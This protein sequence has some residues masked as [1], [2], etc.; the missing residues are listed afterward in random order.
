MSKSIGRRRPTPALH[1]W[2]RPLIGGVAILG[3]LLTGYLALSHFTKSSVA[4][5]TSGCDVVLTSKYAYFLGM[6]L[7]LFGCLAYCAMAVFALAPLLMNGA[8][9]KE[10]RKSIEEGSWLLLFAGSVAMVLFS[11]YLMT[12]LSTEI[13]QFCL[14]CIVS[15]CCTVTMLTLT[16]LGREWK[17]TG[18]LFFIGMIVGMITLLGSLALYASANQ[19]V[20]NNTDPTGLQ[21]LVPQGDPQQGVGWPITTTSGDAEIQLARYLKQSGAKIFTSWTCP[22]CF[23]QKQLFG[24]QALDEL[25][26]VECNP[27]GVNPQLQLCEAAKITGFPSWVI[28]GQLY[29]GVTPLSELARLSGYK[30]PMNFKNFPEAFTPQP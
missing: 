26:R 11:G 30:G 8:N 27:T 19:P 13:R 18:R 29:S 3:A 28:N 14:Y 23:Q 2:S 10:Q 20:V 15:A 25:D 17:D 6:P 5:P 7:S 21:A 16:I 24:K 9:L 1:R 22:H 12:I 4:C